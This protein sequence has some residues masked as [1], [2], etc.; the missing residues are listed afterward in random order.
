M[1]IPVIT[2]SITGN[3]SLFCFSSDICGVSAMEVNT[4]SVDD[5]ETDCEILDREP[6]IGDE[7]E[8]G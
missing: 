5:L 4:E 2:M 7:D 8:L 6:F 1:T 3:F